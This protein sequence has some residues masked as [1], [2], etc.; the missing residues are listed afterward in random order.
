MD[1]AQGRFNSVIGAVHRFAIASVAFW[2]IAV[3]LGGPF[4]LAPALASL[5][6]E[7]RLWEG[8]RGMSGG[9]FPRMWRSALRVWRRGLLVALPIMIVVGALYFATQADLI[10]YKVPAVILAIWGS[11]V[12]H[13]MATR[14]SFDLS[15]WG[16]LLEFFLLSWFHLLALVFWAV[17]FILIFT[18][19]PPL[20]IAFVPAFVAILLRMIGGPVKVLLKAGHPDLTDH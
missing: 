19:S 1:G 10:S 11:M 5:Q 16:T 18:L 4:G 13:H 15:V 12:V 7:V 2:I 20:G 3:C 9:V 6:R 8:I 14:L 17:I